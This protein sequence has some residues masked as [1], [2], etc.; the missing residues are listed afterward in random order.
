[1]SPDEFAKD[2]LTQYIESRRVA[3][4]GAAMSEPHRSRGPAPQ[5]TAG[6]EAKVRLRRT[7]FE[8]H[9]NQPIP[10]GRAQVDALIAAIEAEAAPEPRVMPRDVLREL[11]DAHELTTYD[12]NKSYE[13]FQSWLGCSCGWNANGRT[14]QDGWWD[15]ILAAAPSESD[16]GLDVVREIAKVHLAN[17]GMWMSEP[18]AE[19]T[20]MCDALDWQA[21]A[22]RPAAAGLDEDRLARAVET[23]ILTS[24]TLGPDADEG[25]SEVEWM[26]AAIVAE[27]AR[28]SR[29]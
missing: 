3:L 23:V 4:G 10:E 1:M 15:H 8:A 12:N 26:T 21:L 16:A 18:W 6:L 5:T 7:W 19:F 29:P 11:A 28:Q 24:I 9:P 2:E 27:Y 14:N 13:S 25:M 20:R 22:A 17:H